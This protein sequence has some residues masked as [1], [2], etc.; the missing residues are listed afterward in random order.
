ML[1]MKRGGGGGGKKKCYY[2]VVNDKREGCSVYSF[3]KC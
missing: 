2:S 3:V 1:Y